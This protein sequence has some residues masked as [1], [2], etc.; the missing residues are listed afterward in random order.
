VTRHLTTRPIRN[1]W[2]SDR[3]SWVNMAESVSGSNPTR[4]SRS[5]GQ[6]LSAPFLQRDGGAAHGMR[7]SPAGTKR[8]RAPRSQPQA[9]RLL[10]EEKN[11]VI[12]MGRGSPETAA[13]TALPTMRGNSAVEEGRGE[14]LPSHR[15]LR[16]LKYERAQPPARWRTS[17][18]SLW[19]PEG[20]EE[21]KP[22]RRRELLLRRVGR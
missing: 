10:H 9:K 18:S 5:D 2:I 15:W 12:R 21:G 22:R 20:A 16:V 6:E 11:I 1:P 8:L 13:E 4:T 17:L 14:E 19:A 3:R 7:R